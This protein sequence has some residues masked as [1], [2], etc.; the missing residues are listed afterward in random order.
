MSNDTERSMP[1]KEV[2]SCADPERRDTPHHAEPW[3]STRV[4]QEAEG[5]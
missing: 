1:L 5:V 3:G 4:G 2:L